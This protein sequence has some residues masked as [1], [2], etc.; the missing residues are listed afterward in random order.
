MENVTTSMPPP[1]RT[2][3]ATNIILIL[4]LLIYLALEAHGGA[5]YENL[6]RFGAKENG[7]I[8]VGQWYRIVTPIFLHAGLMH[9][10]FNM[11]ALF[12]VG[13]VLETM[14]GTRSFVVF[15]FIGGVTSTLCSFA[16]SD[17]LS[18]GASGCLYAVLLGLF[19]LQ[20]YEGKLASELGM[21]MPKS[22]LGTLIIL[23]G[24][25]T[26]VIPN[27]DWAAHL[28]G[29]IAGALMGTAIVMRHKWKIRIERCKRYLDPLSSLPRRSL[30][31]VPRFYL[32]LLALVNLG[33]SFR[34]FSTT[35][36]EKNFGLGMLEAS[37][38]PLAPREPA[39]I[40]QFGKLITSEKS[41]TNPLMLAQLGAV[42]HKQG[43]YLPAF[44]LYHSVLLIIENDRGALE[45]MQQA[46][47]NG[48]A[49]QAYRAEKPDDVLIE[50]LEGNAGLEDLGATEIAA[51]CAA[52]ANLMATL[53]FYKISAKLFESAYLMDSY[54][55]Q[56]AV[57]TFASL[58]KTDDFGEILR[59]KEI[60]EDLVPPDEDPILSTLRESAST[61][62][63]ERALDQRSDHQ[64]KHRGTRTVGSFVP[65]SM[66]TVKNKKS[67]HGGKDSEPV[68]PTDPSN[69][70]PPI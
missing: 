19:V 1:R 39:E 10:G 18:V 3:S 51:R 67:N 21:S 28:G 58:K 53:R 26:F 11:Y 49:E 44:L 60:S 32:A 17:A 34:Y 56:Y 29:A 36:V 50:S 8:A 16:L 61:S 41:E 62:A 66:W 64:R 52:A 2:E 5:T 4:N 38:Q 37:Q 31:E 63:S 47:L 22:P 48:L 6:I 46:A 24:L 65:A 59:F 68:A 40:A 14:I 7:L 43:L 9:L 23:N 55:S 12:Q 27:I 13:R 20:R 45:L 42:V 25:I 30:W 15:Y 54:S 57:S 69:L 35:D 33:F 70:S